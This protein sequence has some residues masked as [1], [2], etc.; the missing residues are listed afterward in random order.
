MWF[1]KKDIHKQIWQHPNRKKW[2]CIDYT[3]I[4]KRCLDSCVKQGAECNTDCN[5]LC[6]KLRISKLYLSKH[7]RMN[8]ARFDVFSSCWALAKVRMERVLPGVTFRSLS[9]TL[10]SETWKETEDKWNA[11]KSLLIGA[12]KATIGAN[13]QIGFKEDG[14]VLKPLF[15][16]RN[17]M[18]L[19][20]FGSGLN[21]D[22]EKFSKARST[23][24]KWWEKWKISDS[25]AV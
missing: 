20:W 22:K 5:L 16:E 10:W 8:Q 25:P 21:G 6:T 13:T 4:Q 23:A 12:A 17:Q 7:K 1:K 3:I 2:Y 9:V 18:Y 24:R 14:S 19:R 15:Q 11:L